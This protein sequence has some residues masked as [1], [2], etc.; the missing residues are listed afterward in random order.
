MWIYIKFHTFG[1][2]FYNWIMKRDVLIRF[3]IDLEP[4][5]AWVTF[6]GCTSDKNASRASY[7]RLPCPLLQVNGSLR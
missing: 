1:Y 5:G 2:N 3:T 4:L 7:I 6:Y